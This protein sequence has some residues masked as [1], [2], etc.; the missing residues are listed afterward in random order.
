MD[1]K[2]GNELVIVFS[3]SAKTN[4][5]IEAILCMYQMQKSVILISE[6]GNGKLSKFLEKEI[7]IG[8]GRIHDPKDIRPRTLEYIYAELLASFLML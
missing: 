4:N 7:V 3:A 5:I 1:V 8:N 2:I 6:D